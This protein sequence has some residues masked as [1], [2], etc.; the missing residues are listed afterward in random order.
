MKINILSTCLLLFCGCGPSENNGP[1]PKPKESPVHIVVI[2][3][4]G[5]GA[6][7]LRRNPGAFPHID[8]M[9]KSG[10]CTLRHRSVLPSSSAANWASMLMG[11]SPELHGYTTWGSK[12]PDLPSRT[13]GKYGRFPGIFGLIRAKHPHAATG[14]FYNWEVMDCLFDKGSETL[15]RQGTDAAIARA[16]IRFIQEKQPI[17][18]FIAFHEPDAAGHKHGWLSPEY[19]QQAMEIDRHV[20][21]IRSAIAQ[22]PIASTTYLIFTADHGGQGKNHGG[23]TMA[24]METPFIITGPDNRHNHTIS[25]GTL[26]Y[27]TAATLAA[28]LPLPR[29]QVWIG[30]PVPGIRP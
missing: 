3:A 6:E 9:M 2:G 15:C 12:Q 5:F 19:M 10:A 28:L 20:G 29:P 16:A 27:D 25:E 30:R 17:L 22:S 13:I 23:K 7:T 8:F 26:M 21:E 14:Y 4:D 1:Q 24:E 18:T 11:A